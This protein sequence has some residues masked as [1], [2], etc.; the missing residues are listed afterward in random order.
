M[1]DIPIVVLSA[2]RSPDEPR[3]DKKDAD[4]YAELLKVLELM[5]TPAKAHS[6]SS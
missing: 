3:A 2:K 1:F 4:I 5:L 6:A